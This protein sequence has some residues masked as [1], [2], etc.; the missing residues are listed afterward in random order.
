[1]GEHNVKEFCIY[2]SCKQY[3][4]GFIKQ[5]LEII[6]EKY[7]SDKVK[8]KENVNSNFHGRKYF[9][10]CFINESYVSLILDPVAS[11]LHGV[12]YHKC[13]CQII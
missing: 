2:I 4:A 10:Y 6:F 3:K 7:Y 1:M 12:R 13:W 11:S 9:S 5:E 8:T